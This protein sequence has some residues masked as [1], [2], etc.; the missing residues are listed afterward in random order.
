LYGNVQLVEKDSVGS[1]A[2][3]K[4]WQVDAAK[5]S[6]KHP[7]WMAALWE[8][9]TMVAGGLRCPQTPMV[10]ASLHKLVVGDL[11]G[12]FKAHKDTEKQP[13]MFATMVRI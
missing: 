5:V 11:G 10:T 12:F 4:T 7:R 8:L 1:D 9:T 2:V 6:F 3:C 13:G